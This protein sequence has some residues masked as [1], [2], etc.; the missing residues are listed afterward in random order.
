MMTYKA[1]LDE[2]RFLLNDVLQLHDVLSLDA[3]HSIDSGLVDAIL[4]EAGKF[5]SSILS[6]LNAKGDR[7]GCQLDG[8]IVKTPRGF[9]EA[10]HTFT[11]NGWNSV[12]FPPE[13]GGQ[14][15][16]WIIS[17]AISE[18]WSGANM[19]FALCPLLT[20]GAVELLLHHGSENQ[21]QTYLPKLISGEYTGTMCLTEPQAG[22]DLGAIRTNASPDGGHYR[23]NGQKIYIT[24]GEHDF[25]S[26][27]I[28]MVLA[29]LP[30]APEGPKGISL[31]IVPKFLSDGSRNDV[32]AL[33]L[34]HKMG[35][36]ASPTAVLS[37]GED[38]KGA[39]GYL[40]G[41]PHRG[42]S[43]MFTMMNNA[44][45]AV[46]IEGIALAENSLQQATA[47]AAERLQFKTTIQHH[48]DVKRMLLHMRASIEAMRGLA[49]LEAK[50]LDMAH[51]LNDPRERAQYALQA[52]FLTPIIKAHGTDIG[53]EVSSMAIQTFG[54]MGYM[55]ETGVE[56]NLRDAKIAQIYEGTNG[57]Q[58]IDF[59][60]RKLGLEGVVEHFIVSMRS[61]PALHLLADA[62][63]NCTDAI[64]KTLQ[65]DS[66]KVLFI[67]TP[68]LRLWGIALSAWMME[69]RLEASKQHAGLHEQQ[70]TSTEYYRNFCLPEALSLAETIRSAVHRN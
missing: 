41:E 12:P 25:T 70:V 31:F 23:I 36:H 63:E 30:D 6:P 69:Q 5:A 29:R 47:Y 55:R 21:K 34:E 54:G 24:Y 48:P 37:F 50:A 43:C 17:S 32:K 57:I 68:H 26:N 62:L 40:V 38:G 10:Y 52:A 42:L 2:F 1:P 35:I 4:D 16:P 59:L 13:Y 20:Q 65:H 18:C 19:A 49:L 8:H 27:I 66:N 22:S 44:R 28:H 11:N 56:Q 15:L 33:S 61:Y 53:F 7:D 64:S 67:A 39:I 14:G 9:K 60:T 3:F 51:H 46:G 45:L 58:A